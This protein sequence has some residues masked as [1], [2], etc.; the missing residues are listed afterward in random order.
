ME[1]QTIGMNQEEKLE[2]QQPKEKMENDL[3][4]IFSYFC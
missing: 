1:L 3:T 2:E 4:P